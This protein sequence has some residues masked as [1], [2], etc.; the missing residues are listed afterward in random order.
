MTGPFIKAGDFLTTEDGERLYEVLKDQYQEDLFMPENFRGVDGT[1]DPEHG[2][3]IDNRCFRE[4][5]GSHL[6]EVC[7]NGAWR[8]VPSF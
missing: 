7:V 4:I 8:K 6:R 2:Q 3:I 5:P 1:L